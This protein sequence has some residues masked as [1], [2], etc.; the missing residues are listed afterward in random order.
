[1]GG[2]DAATGAGPAAAWKSLSMVNGTTFGP[3]DTILLKAGSV[4]GWFSN[5]KRGMR[6]KKMPKAQQATGMD[7]PDTPYRRKQRMTWAALIKAVYEVSPLKCPNCGGTMRI[8]SFIEKRQSD[9]VEKIL[10]HC[11]LWMVAEP[12]RSKEPQPRPP[13]EEPE[14][15]E[16]PALDY[17]FTSASSVRRFEREIS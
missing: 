17:G 6:Q 8:V 4:F 14:S 16:E 10:R 3:G 2:S 1:V 7:E 9:V 12:G 5:K 13:P 15:V 11:G